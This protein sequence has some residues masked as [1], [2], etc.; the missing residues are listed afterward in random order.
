[1]NEINCVRIFFKNESIQREITQKINLT[2][3]LLR[4][5]PLFDLNKF[6]KF[7]NIF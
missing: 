1:M 3:R 6:M 5:T 7:N 2:V 4:A